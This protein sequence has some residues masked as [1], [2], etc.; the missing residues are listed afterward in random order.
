M[1]AH[2]KDDSGL[3]EQVG[4]H[5]GPDDLKVFRKVNLDILAEATRVIV[6]G[7]LGISCSKK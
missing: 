2:L 5:V 7:G 4:S 1:A 6:S 3:F